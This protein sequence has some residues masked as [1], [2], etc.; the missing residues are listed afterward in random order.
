MTPYPTDPGEYGPDPEEL[1]R[2]E[3][4]VEVCPHCGF[5]YVYAPHGACPRC[6]R[7]VEPDV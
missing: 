5:E 1:E 6:R 7:P 4:E 3:A 2:Q